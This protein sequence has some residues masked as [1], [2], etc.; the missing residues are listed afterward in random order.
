M[1][2]M[3]SICIIMKLVS[4]T[5]WLERVIYGVTEEAPMVVHEQTTPSRGS[6]IV[7]LSINDVGMREQ[8]RGETVIIHVNS[9]TTMQPH[10]AASDAVR[11]T[12]IEIEA[13]TR[14]VISDYSY[15]KIKALQHNNLPVTEMPKRI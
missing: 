15:W 11:K 14:H 8:R 6:C 12:L 5:Q 2:A 10:V 7:S 1:I 3:F 13:Q 9:F 4:P